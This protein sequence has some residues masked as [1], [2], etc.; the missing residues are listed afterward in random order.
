[1]A[2]ASARVGIFIAFGKSDFIPLNATFEY[3]DDFYV[4]SISPILGP[5]YGG[6]VS[7]TGAG[8]E[9]YPKCYCKFG[10]VQIEA[11]LLAHLCCVANHR[12]CR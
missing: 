9:C 2:E 7:I 10:S 12:S 6:T 4:H 8:F 3:G 5:K 11:G 1:M